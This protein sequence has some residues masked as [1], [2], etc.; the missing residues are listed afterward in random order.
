MTTLPPLRKSRGGG[1][2]KKKKKAMMTVW[3]PMKR[4]ELAGAWRLRG[5]AAAAAAA[6]AGSGW[7]RWLPGAESEAPADMSRETHT[8]NRNLY[9]SL[10]NSSLGL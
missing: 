10:Q 9:T 6:A 3:G 8:T 5:A 4:R 7:L 1:R 2:K